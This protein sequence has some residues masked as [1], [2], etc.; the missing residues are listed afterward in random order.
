[1]VSQNI[2]VRDVISACD[3]G[4]VSEVFYQNDSLRPDNITEKEKADA[5]ERI[6]LSLEKFR[7]DLLS[8]PVAN[9]PDRYVMF[10]M[11]CW[12]D[13]RENI[14]SC[15]Y[16]EKDF[17]RMAEKAE[18]ADPPAISAITKENAESIVDALFAE[19]PNAS[20]GYEFMEWE[21]VLAA[22]VIPGNAERFGLN[23]FAADILWN[24]SF[25]GMKREEQ[26]KRRVDLK[27]SI[28]E[29][30]DIRSLPK[31]EQEKHYRSFS[32]EEVFEKFGLTLPTKEEREETRKQMYL[33]SAKTS[34]AK[35]LEFRRIVREE[36]DY[37]SG[38]CDH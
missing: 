31:E 18:N 3:L 28:Q 8:L 9:T 32:V 33:D 15:L 26:E 25:N 6:R 37:V 21:E 12:D 14:T 19:F 30:E 13:G 34:A 16:D 7:R 10:A 17:L 22:K 20:I 38:I 23:L 29:M 35:V 11:R 5:V 36:K 27:K 4:M 2:T 24:M 1:M